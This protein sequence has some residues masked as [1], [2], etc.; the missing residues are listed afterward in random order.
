MS[1]ITQHIQLQA[2]DPIVELFEL[3]CSSLGGSIYRFTPAVTNNLTSIQFGGHTW[4]PIPIK[5]EGLSNNANEAPSQ[6]TLTISN[7]TLELVGPIIALRDLVGAKLIRYR[8]FER[9]LATGSSPDSTALLPKDVYIIMKKVVQN[10][11]NIQW[12]LASTLDKPS[13]KIPRRLFLKKDFPGL[14]SYRPT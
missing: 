6:P 14:S 8:T 9:F 12:Q 11:V 13:L 2:T 4:S 3:D 7:I 10:N 5:I 1:A